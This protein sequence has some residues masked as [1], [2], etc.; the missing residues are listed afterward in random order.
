MEWV[1][2][3]THGWHWSVGTYRDTPLAHGDAESWE[4][5]MARGW[6]EWRF[7]SHDPTLW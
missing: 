2:K 7:W 4:Q 3:D 5:A 1:W 6:L